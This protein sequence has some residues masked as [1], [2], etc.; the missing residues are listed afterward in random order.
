MSEPGAKA[1]NPLLTAPILPL[2]LKFALPNMVAMLATALAAIAETAYVGRFGSPALAGMALV[3][4][5]VMFQMMLS[6]GAMGGGVSSA[7]S[8]ALGAG[9]AVRANALAVHA[10]WIALAAGGVYMVAMLT[11]GE[12]VLSALGGQGE[13]L[14][15]AMAYGNVA[16]L[17]SVFVWLV[18]T[19]ASVSRGAGNMAAPSLTLFVVALLQVALGGA[20]GLGWGPWPP[21]GMAGVAAGGVIAYGAGAAWLWWT[22]ASGR[23]RISLNMRGTRFERALFADILRVGAV[24][25]ISPLQTVLTILILTRLVAQF[26][27]DALA[28]YG[29]GTRLEF[30][31]VPVA[32]AIGV[33][34]VP[35][36]GMAI[37]AGLVARARRAA[38]TAAALA[39]AVLGGLGLIVTLAPD[40]WTG[41][42][43]QDPAVLD[44]A[45]GY[46]RWAG[47]VYG[48]FGLGLSLYF[49]S[50]GAGKAIGP[51]LA[52]TLRLVMVAGGGL[53]L[54][55]WQTPTWTI[56]AL[57]S[58]GMAVYGLS[59]VLF[60]RLTPW[61]VGKA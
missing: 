39:T 13:A 6:G 18:N 47:P 2:L 45:A 24:A 48:L 52:G 29:I 51:V 33:A 26:G 21:L 32:F 10:V 17:G 46:F 20:L 37:G 56:F 35:L 53:L 55:L 1:P 8:R 16:F 11:L 43:S 14:A 50:L 3:F 57:L 27:T 7:V 44:A 34:S 12:A 31:L 59:S 28:G 4:P 49:S 19:L 15:Q 23:A 54:A 41:L 5:F 60:V 38:W 22:L 61:G 30:L 58:A 40:L 36:V 25:C 9:D 42:F